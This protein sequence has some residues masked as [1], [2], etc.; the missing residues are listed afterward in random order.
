M[1]RSRADLSAS[2]V[3][4]IRQMVAAGLPKAKVARQH[5]ITIGTLNGILNG[6]LKA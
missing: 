5:D 4:E 1:S 6:I 3:S 2:E